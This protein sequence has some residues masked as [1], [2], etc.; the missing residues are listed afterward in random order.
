MNKKDLKTGMRVETAKGH[1]YTVSADIGQLNNT[2][3][4]I[5]MIELNDDLTCCDPRDTIIKVTS[6]GKGIHLCNEFVEGDILWER[7][8]LEVGKWYESDKKAMI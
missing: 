7:E 5:N 3:S 4:W 8:E 6:G 2:S 1:L